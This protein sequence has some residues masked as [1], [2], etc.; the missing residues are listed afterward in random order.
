MS[1][2][3]LRELGLDLV[4][5]EQWEKALGVFAE[6]VRRQPADHRSRMLAARCYEKLSEPER[7]VT[8]LHA[9]AEGLLRRDYLLSAISACKQALVLAPYEKRLKE[10]L[11]RIH[12]RAAK[13]VAGKAAGPP[14][15]PPDSLFDGKVAED[16]MSLQ[17]SQ[18]S[19]AAINVLAS[20]DTGGNAD[21]EAR[22]P[23]P[24]FADLERDAFV[25]L[26]AC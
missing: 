26:V 19:D 7:A 8:T 10:T 14:P 5:E 22:P 23:L 17:G 1:G 12:A 3:S 9:C 6:A 13:T 11:H 24:L 15:L 21:S 25:E 2:S 18:L 16:L 20:S 4:A